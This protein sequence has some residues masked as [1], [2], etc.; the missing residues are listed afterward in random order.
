MS[1]AHAPIIGA[2]VHQG[3][4]PIPQ[5]LRDRWATVLLAA[6][7]LV[8][9]MVPV[10]PVALEYD[11]ARLQDVWRLMTCHF[12]HFDLV[13]LFWSGSMFVAL[14]A[15]LEPRGRGRLLLC[16]AASALAIP[17]ALF[18]WAPDLPTYRGSSGIDSALFAMALVAFA[19]EARAEGRRGSVAL[20]V[21]VGA[22]FVAK[23]VYEVTVGA[24]V[25][26]DSAAFEP[27]PLAHAVGAAVGIAVTTSPCPRGVDLQVVLGQ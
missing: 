24:A 2:A 27:V 4:P 9:F 12:A 18:V 11:R 23:L 20:C 10:L 7:V 17:V 13:H 3:R 5:W 1:Q 15:L 6:A 16:I 25:F 21:L 22:G 14:A 8:A 19:R 26:A